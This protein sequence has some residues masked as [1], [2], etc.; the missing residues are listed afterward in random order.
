[1]SNHP[2]RK[3]GV[4]ALL[5][6]AVLFSSYAFSPVPEQGTPQ[7]ENNLKVLPKD[8]SHTELMQVMHS[9]E[10]ALGYSCGDCH[11]RSATD[12][13]KLDFASEDNPK[14]GEALEMMKMVQKINE[15]SFEVKGDF[16]DNYLKSQY[17]VSCITCHNGHAEPAHT[18]SIPI[19]DPRWEKK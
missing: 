2:H 18:I 10:I 7:H 17:K 13:N 15:H 5:G 3:I 1:M 6:G 12:T 14:K 8:I 9:F 4:L 16:K 11:A 19:P